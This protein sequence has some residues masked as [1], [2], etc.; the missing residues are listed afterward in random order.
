[1]LIFTIAAGSLFCDTSL[2]GPSDH[3]QQYNNTGTRAALTFARPVGQ[4]CVK[5]QTVQAGQ[6]KT[7]KKHTYHAHHIGRSILSRTNL[8][9]GYG[10]MHF[11][12]KHRPTTS[13]QTPPPPPPPLALRWRRRH[14]SLP[15]KSTAVTV[16]GD[17]RGGGGSST[18]HPLVSVS[19]GR[20]VP[21]WRGDYRR[22][23]YRASNSRTNWHPHKTYPTSVSNFSPCR[24][25]SSH[26]A[27]VK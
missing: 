10:E 17:Y 1:M 23:Q 20:A 19:P 2:F 18:V 16:G 12:W 27:S 6:N 25:R 22:L 8:R 11:S 5:T 26:V 7:K 21:G 13:P 15:T 9:L 4:S 14:H 3:V 24:S